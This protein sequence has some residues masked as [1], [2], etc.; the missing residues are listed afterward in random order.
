MNEV[1]DE[2]EDEDFPVCDIGSSEDSEGQV[3]DDFQVSHM[4]EIDQRKSY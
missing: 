4:Q 3:I 1:S 2:E